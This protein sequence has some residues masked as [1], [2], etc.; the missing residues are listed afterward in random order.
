MSVKSQVCALASAGVKQEVI[1][2]RLNISASYVSQLLQEE[3]LR[4]KVTKAQLEVLDSRTQRDAQY[5]AIEDILLEKTKKIANTL[6]KPQDILR[7]L[8][9]INKAE[10]RGASSQQLAEITRAQESSVITLDLPERVKSRVV[11]SQTKEIVS[12]DG[13]ALITK[14]SRLLLEEIQAEMSAPELPLDPYDV[15]LGDIND[16]I[17]QSGQGI[18]QSGQ[19]KSQASANT[20]S[21][22]LLENS[23][24]ENIFEHTESYETNG[25]SK[26]E[27]VPV[28]SRV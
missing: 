3:E 11:K 14:D 1:A 13:R 16:F 23:P 6:Y 27:S 5:D 18:P 25:H 15:D 7:A 20:S 10:R 24:S 17:P 21:K 2:S 26:L 8:Q 19:G 22:P 12:V 4:A 28:P 9:A